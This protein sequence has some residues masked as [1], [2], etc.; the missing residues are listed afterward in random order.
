MAKLNPK[1]NIRRA[2]QSEPTRTTNY[3]GGVAFTMNDKLRLYTRVASCLVGEPKFYKEVDEETGRITADNQDDLLLKDLATVARLEPEFILKLAAYA[4]NNLYLRTIPTVMLV[5]ASLIP[6]TKPFVRR[7]APFIIKR[8]DE[9][10]EAM[11]YLQAKIGNIGSKSPKGSMPA[12]LKKGLADSFH[13]F[14]AYQFGKY[15]RDGAVKLKDVLKVVHPKP[16]NDAESALFLSIKDETL[17]SPET[18]ETVISGKGSTKENW[19][20]I[21][22]KMPYMATLRNLRNF[23]EKGVDADSLRIVLARLSDPE[24]VKRSKQFPFRYF[25]AYREIE[26]VGSPYTTKTLDT[27]ET[28]LDISVANLP[29]FAGTTFI[30]AD[31]SGSMSAPLSAKGSVRREDVANLLMAI[32]NALC[33]FPICSIFGDDFKVKN[34]SQR[35]GAIAN[36]RTIRNDE[37]GS[38]TNAYKA[39]DYLINNRIKVDRIILFSDMQCYDS[40]HRAYTLMSS[41]N[42]GYESNIAASFRKYKTTVN[43]KVYLYSIDLAGYGT[44]QTPENE[45]NVMTIA[46]WTEKILNFIP[47]F[48]SDKAT[49]VQAID[50]YKPI[51]RLTPKTTDEG[52]EA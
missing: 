47:I 13:N 48:E 31:N 5:E 12:A 10:T 4:R 38:S 26:N 40:S 32:S 15:N 27:L 45:P 3:E 20:S 7:Y 28:A 41:Y 52:T 50:N 18:W 44:S 23:L 36:M 37:V 33:E 6:E 35:N 9:L 42:Y 14:D 49:A 39:F 21:I 25:S 29:R 24:Q 16:L 8:A 2:V 17:A 30:T 34:M 19:E 43:P 1:A 22:P 46:G 51:K 11:A